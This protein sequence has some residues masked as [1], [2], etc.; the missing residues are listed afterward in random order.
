MIQHILEWQPDDDVVEQD[1]V[2]HAA[3]SMV[4]SDLEIMDTH[5]FLDRRPSHIVMDLIE[6]IT[7]TMEEQIEEI[8]CMKDMEEDMLKLGIEHEQKP[9]PYSK[10][11]KVVNENHVRGARIIAHYLSIFEYIKDR[12]NGER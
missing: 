3:R 10:V 8:V 5:S 4:M 7:E 1:E 12:M 9:V 2:I 6:A 11:I